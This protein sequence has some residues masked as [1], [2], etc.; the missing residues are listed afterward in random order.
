MSNI[1]KIKAVSV[2]ATSYASGG[3]RTFFLNKTDNLQV[4]REYEEGDLFNF[5]V[6]VE[7]WNNSKKELE[8]H[9]LDFQSNAIGNLYSLH[10]F[11]PLRDKIFK[12]F[13]VFN[14]HLAHSLIDVQIVLMKIS[15]SLKYYDERFS[16]EIIL[17][18]S[19]TIEDVTG[20]GLSAMGKFQAMISFFYDCVILSSKDKKTPS[21]NEQ[22]LT[23]RLLIQYFESDEFINDLFCNYGIKEQ[24]TKFDLILED[25]STCSA[26]FSRVVASKTGFAKFLKDHKIVDFTPIKLD[27]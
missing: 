21:T 18:E 20:H 2:I 19:E 5:R 10:H 24:V 27:I 16:E 25:N 7:I 14:G 17:T 6:H 13:E 23:Q 9:S 12:L 11:Q 4:S 8:N 15:E 3:M 22:R 26:Y 1:S